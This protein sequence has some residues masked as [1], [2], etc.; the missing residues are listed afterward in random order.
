LQRSSV[1][2]QLLPLL[3]V[4]I[5]SALVTSQ[6]LTTVRQNLTVSEEQPRGSIIGRISVA[7][8]EPPYYV[9][10]AERGDVRKILVSGDGLVTVGDRIDR[11]EKSLYRLIAHSSNN[12]QVEVAVQLLLL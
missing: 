11:E 3:L 5:W 6:R 4:S 2:M 9:Y 12:I 8:A 7:S 10:Y 1:A